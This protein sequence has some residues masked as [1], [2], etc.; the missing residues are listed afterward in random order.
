[1]HSNQRE[2][3]THVSARRGTTWATKLTREARRRR[4]LIGDY[5]CINDFYSDLKFMSFMFVCLVPVCVYQFN[6][7]CILFSIFH[8]GKKDTVIMK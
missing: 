6:V 8:Y 5:L 7:T 1:M 2:K 3:G 4:T